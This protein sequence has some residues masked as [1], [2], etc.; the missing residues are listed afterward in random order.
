MADE[1]NVLPAPVTAA[2]EA[3]VASAPEAPPAPRK[4]HVD[5]F[6]E[7]DDVAKAVADLPRLT[8]AGFIAAHQAPRSREEWDAALDSFIHGRL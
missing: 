6:L 7:N 1:V 8:I 5:Q 4:L 2:P 3:P